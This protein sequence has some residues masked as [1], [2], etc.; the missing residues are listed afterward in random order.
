M[1]Y[2]TSDLHLG[3]RNI[4]RFERKEFDTTEAHDEYIRQVIEKKVS[5]NDTL[6][7]LGDIGSGFEWLQDVGAER[8]LIRGNHDTLAKSRYEEIFTEV[9]DYPIYLNKR[10]L[11]SHEPQLCDR[12]VLNI[13]GHLHNSIV[14]LP[15]YF[16]ANICLCHYELLSMRDLTKM[17]GDIPRDRQKHKFT[18]EWWA[19]HQVYTIPL[20]EI[21]LTEDGHLD[22][23]KQR[24]RIEKYKAQKDL[25]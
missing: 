10:I 1:I 8:Y 6:W 15:N 21:A 14:D 20:D 19:P 11:L 17:I 5:R 2:I 25:G 9:F 23:E 22:I 13:H 24:E 3:H 16:N 4:V 18:Y 12:D 7:V